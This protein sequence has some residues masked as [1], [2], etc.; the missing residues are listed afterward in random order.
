MSW[1]YE[2]RQSCLLRYARVTFTLVSMELS[3]RKKPTSFSGLGLHMLIY[4][5]GRRE[6]KNERERERKKKRKI[7][8]KR[9]RKRERDRAIKRVREREI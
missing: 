7:E 3:D 6:R 9:K 5:V 2:R 4:Y 1:C 8:R